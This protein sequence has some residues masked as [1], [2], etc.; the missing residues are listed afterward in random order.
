MCGICGL[1]GVPACTVNG[2]C[3]L[4]IQ[5]VIGV[6]AISGGAAL[7]LLRHWIA[8]RLRPLTKIIKKPFKHGNKKI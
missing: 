4:N 3:G 5:Q 1:T 7:T 2:A 8:V 6:A